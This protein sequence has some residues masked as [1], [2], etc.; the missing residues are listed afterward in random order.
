MVSIFSSQLTPPNTE[1][2]PEMLVALHAITSAELHQT[3][4]HANDDYLAKM[5]KN[6]LVTGIELV[7]D[8]RG[9]CLSCVRAKAHT[10]N[11]SKD[12]HLPE[13]SEPLQIIHCD[14]AGPHPISKGGNSFIAAIV[15]RKTKH[16]WILLLKMFRWVLFILTIS[17]EELVE[18]CNNIGICK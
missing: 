16:K 4:A 2:D 12:S 18:V 1:W 8:D 11:V 6:G 7:M 5:V 9:Q 13:A 3:M 15:D 14:L 17:S 10:T